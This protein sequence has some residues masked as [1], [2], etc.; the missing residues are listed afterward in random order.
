MQRDVLSPLT[1]MVPPQSTRLA[2]G[3]T[4]ELVSPST[5]RVATI[6]S[7]SPVMQHL[8]TND[9]EAER[10]ARRRSRV[11]ELQS[12]Q[13]ASPATSATPPDKLDLKFYSA[14]LVVVIS[15][16]LYTCYFV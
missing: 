2:R 4:K 9:D 13:I 11:M 12:R 16:Q 3:T 6:T 7:P 14:M 5:R 10:K 15:L 8:S 1:P